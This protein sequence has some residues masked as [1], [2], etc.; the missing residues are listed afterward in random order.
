MTNFLAQRLIWTVFAFSR[1]WSARFGSFHLI[2]LRRGV[3]TK[4]DIAFER[5]QFQIH[6]NLFF[7]RPDPYFNRHEAASS[8]SARAINANSLK[9]VP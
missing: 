7:L 3:L 8:R 4:I 5:V 6:Q 2:A 9:R 1:H